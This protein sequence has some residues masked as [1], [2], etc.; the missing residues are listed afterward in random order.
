MDSVPSGPSVAVDGST[1]PPQCGHVTAFTLSGP[2]TPWTPGPTLSPEPAA[3]ALS[4]Y[5]TSRNG[6]LGRRC[7]P[8]RGAGEG[9]CP[10]PQPRGETPRGRK[11]PREG[12][13]ARQGRPP[14]RRAPRKGTGWTK[15]SPPCGY[16]SRWPAPSQ[17]NGNRAARARRADGCPM[18]S[19]AFATRGEWRW[20]LARIWRARLHS[21]W[22]SKARPPLAVSLVRCFAVSI[23][24][25]SPAATLS[26]AGSGRHRRTPSP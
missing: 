24:S 11:W 2:G 23:P 12:P 20:R 4:A 22:G 19:T 9:S 16:F 13:A 5:R 6:R 8:P 17:P 10:R 21:T 3:P 26:G 14:G 7:L 18:L 1:W 15:A 25:A